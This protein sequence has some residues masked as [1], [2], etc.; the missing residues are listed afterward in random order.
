VNARVRE[1][2]AAGL[3]AQLRDRLKPGGFLVLA[4]DD[5]RGPIG[6]IVRGCQQQG[7]Q[8]WQHVVAI[9]PGEPEQESR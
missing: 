5:A 6:A 9:D 4:P 7:L 1:R 2:S 3:A 8:Y